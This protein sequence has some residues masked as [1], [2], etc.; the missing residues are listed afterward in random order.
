M[1]SFQLKWS[2]GEVAASK[3]YLGI[4]I[5]LMHCNVGTLQVII[6]EFLWNSLLLIAQSCYCEMFP[7]MGT[8]VQWNVDTCYLHLHL[9]GKDKSMQTLV[10]FSRLKSWVHCWLL[11]QQRW[12]YKQWHLP[13]WSQEETFSQTGK[14]GINKEVVNFGGLKFE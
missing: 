3:S 10:K 2:Q 11:T 8:T 9:D 1:S 14:V 5:D 6:T 4:G 12:T 13:I 7:T